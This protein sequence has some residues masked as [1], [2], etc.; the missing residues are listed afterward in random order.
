MVNFTVSSPHECVFVTNPLQYIEGKVDLKQ[1]KTNEDLAEFVKT[2]FENDNIIDLYT[3][4]N[5]YDILEILQNDALFDDDYVSDKL[6]VED[7]ENLDDVCDIL[8]GKRNF[9]GLLD[10]NRVHQIL[11]VSV[12]CKSPQVLVPCLDFRNSTL[13]ILSPFICCIFAS[14]SKWNCC[15]KLVAFEVM[16]FANF[17][18]FGLKEDVEFGH[19]S[20]NYS[21]SKMN[22][23]LDN[24][25]RQ[26]QRNKG[27]PNKSHLN[28]R[29]E[30]KSFSSIF[31]S[32]IPWNASVQDLWDIC[33]KWGVVIDVYIAA[34]RSKSGHRFGFVRFINVNDINQ[35][36]SNLRTA[37]MGGFH[38][39]ADVAKYGRTYNRPVERSGDGKP[40]VGSNSQ[41]VSINENVF[42]SFNSY[43]KAVL[44][45]K[46]VDMS[47]KYG[48]SNAG[49]ES[50]G[51]SDCNKV[52]KEAGNEAVMSI[53]VDDCI[54]LDGMERSILAKVKDLSVISELLKH[55]S[56]E[57]F[58]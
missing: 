23:H 26:E 18:V 57:G 20:N 55:M 41:S 5:G 30:H 47:G 45:N 22:D 33:N 38:L 28:F 39:F 7:K 43:A 1:L 17:G 44:G 4:H 27:I 40:S 29:E 10:D 42:Q 15:W 48:T 13:P 31:V 53:S 49:A 58:D 19:R 37:W 6:D 2:C 36:V 21:E 51:V 14:R 12:N 8:V 24:N 3:E 34:K 35:L 52:Y 11:P 46:S 32:N 54:D 9:I 25:R 56:S 16:V 50:V